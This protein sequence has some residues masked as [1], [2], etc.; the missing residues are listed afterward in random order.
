[1]TVKDQLKILD[2]KI[3]Q[4]KADYDLYI[5]NAEISALSSGDLDKYEYLTGKDLEY[6]PDPIQKAKFEYSPLGQVFNKGLDSTEKQKGFLKRLKNIEDKTDNQLK[7]IKGQKNNQ[8][9]KSIGYRIN[10][11]LPKEAVEGYNI[12]LKEDSIIDYQDLN[13]DFGSSEYTFSIFSSAGDLFTE[14]YKKNISLLDAEKE[15]EKF[16]LKLKKLIEYEPLTE[17]TTKKRFFLKK[18]RKFL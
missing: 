6:K 10:D 14:L 13:K 7:A 11:Q 4:N 16:Y 17:N 1:M 18:Y 15:Q 2:R 9:I 5:Q 12:L 8:S 3:R